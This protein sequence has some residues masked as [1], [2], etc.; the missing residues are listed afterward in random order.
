MYSH[1]IYEHMHAHMYT[2]YIRGRGVPGSGRNTGGFAFDADQ[3][4][5]ELVGPRGS[6]GRCG[7]GMKYGCG[8]VCAN[9]VPGW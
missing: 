2:V 5:R 8:R 7:A 3:G 1:D 9:V 6:L 4:A